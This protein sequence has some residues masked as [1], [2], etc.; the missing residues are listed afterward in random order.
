[1][2]CLIVPNFEHLEDWA[3]EHELSWSSHEELIGLDE[4]KAK[5]QRGLDRANAK[6]E[7]FSTVKTFALLRDEFTLERNELTPTLKVKRRVIQ[8]KY[9]EVIEGLYSS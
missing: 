1:M 4:I 6:L 3:R 2:I 7:S 9:A 8:D 5:Y